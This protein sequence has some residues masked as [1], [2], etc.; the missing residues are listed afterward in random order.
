LAPNFH[1]PKHELTGPVAAALSGQCSQTAPAIA[2]ATAAT[3]TASQAR[4]A[5]FVALDGVTG[6]NPRANEL[7]ARVADLLNATA[8]AYDSN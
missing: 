7:A 2:V 1:V 3:A 5:W 8:L 6:R 4:R